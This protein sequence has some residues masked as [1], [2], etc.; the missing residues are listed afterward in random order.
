VE[1]SVLPDDHLWITL[2]A[3][4]ADVTSRQLDVT[5]TGPISQAILQQL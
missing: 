4:G 2:S 3:A 5:A 1:R